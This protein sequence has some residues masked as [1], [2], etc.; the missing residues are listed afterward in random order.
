MTWTSEPDYV[1]GML[2]FLVLFDLV[3]LS[4]RLEDH[5]HSNF[6]VIRHH[7]NSCNIGIIPTAYIRSSDLRWRIRYLAPMGIFMPC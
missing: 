4:S 7:R 3:S 5:W 1:S 6:L 2:G